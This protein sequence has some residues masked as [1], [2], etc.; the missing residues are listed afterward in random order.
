[1]NL[2]VDITPDILW[3]VMQDNCDVQSAEDD[4]FYRHSDHLWFSIVDNGAPWRC[5]PIPA[6]HAIWTTPGKPDAIRL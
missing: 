6:L 3:T 2:E 5:N 1:M 4:I